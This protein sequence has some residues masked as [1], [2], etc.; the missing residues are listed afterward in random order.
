MNL[1][2]PPSARNRFAKVAE[3]FLNEVAVLLFV[4][5]VLDEYIQFGKRGVTTFV[6]AT[7][8]GASLGAFALA[9]AIAVYTRE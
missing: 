3:T 8:L 9:S 2:P 7:S 5:P 6:I 4:F 1:R